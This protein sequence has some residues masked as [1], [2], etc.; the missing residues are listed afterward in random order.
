[1]GEGEGADPPEVPGQRGHPEA[2]RADS[3]HVPARSLVMDDTSCLGLR[4]VSA[5]GG[6]IPA[7]VGFHTIFSY[8]GSILEKTGSDVYLFKVP[9]KW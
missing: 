5:E 7:G 3:G 6:R 2:L 8:L 1:M 9:L 4:T